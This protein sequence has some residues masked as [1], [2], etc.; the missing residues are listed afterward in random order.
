MV[1]NNGLVRLALLT[2]V[3][4]IIVLVVYIW[5]IKSASPNGENNATTDENVNYVNLDELMGNGNDTQVDNA[6]KV[7]TTTNVEETTDNA[8]VKPVETTKDEKLKVVIVKEG[9][10]VSFP[11]LKAV[12]PDKDKIKWTFSKPLD[13]KGTWETKKGDAGTYEVSITASDGKE[14][15]AQKVM[16]IV[17][18]KNSLPVID[19]PSSFEFKEGETITL[20]PKITDADKD[21]LDITYSGFMDSNTKTLSYD[22]AGQHTVTIKVSD[23]KDTVSKK[24]TINVANINRAPVI[25]NI[26]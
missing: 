5:N 4:V 26:I 15:T 13:D 21:P 3:V 10:I 12:D 11:N 6:A 23:G 2:A 1:R 16:I 14:S 18:S 8:K 7:D 22:D 25:T 9:D 17:E 24:I 20:N 19:I